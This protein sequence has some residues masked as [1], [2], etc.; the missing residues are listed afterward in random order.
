M[1]T[2]EPS[3]SRR[4]GRPLSFDRGRRARAGDAAVL[5]ARLRDHLGRGPHGCDGDKPAQPLHGVRRQAAAVPRGDAA[6]RRRP[7]AAGRDVWRR[8]EHRARR[9]ARDA[10]D[11]RRSR[12]P[13][14][15]RRGGACWPAPRPAGR[16]R[17]RM[18]ARRCPRCAGDI[19]ARVAGPDR[20]RRRGGDACQARPTSRQPP[21]L[22]MAVVQG[23][24]VL[25]RDG[26]P[27]ERLLALV[28]QAM[29]AWPAGQSG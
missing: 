3:R 24:S 19:C 15:R 27:R 14:R 8:R 16:R 28:E 22:A 6:L 11:P 1:E 23:M 20:T 4:T 12:S 7:G 2:A 21:T 25:A 9:G 18:S 5:E 29:Q 10:R 17:R 26:V 13:A